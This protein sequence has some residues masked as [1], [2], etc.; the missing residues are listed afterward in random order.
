MLTTSLGQVVPYQQIE[1]Y[2]CGAA[3]LK[4]V[5][6]HWG[7]NYDEKMLIDL[8]GVD[9]M[10][11]S[12]ADQVATAAQRLGYNATVHQFD[13]I[14]ELRQYTDRDM[15]VIAA[16]RS[17]TRPGQG[18]FVV[19]AEVDD[20]TVDI[21]D[22][23]VDGN[24]RTLARSEMASRWRFRDNVGVIVTPRDRK[25]SRSSLG[26]TGTHSWIVAAIVGGLVAATAATVAVVRYR[27]RRQAAT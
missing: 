8:I 5:T 26:G 16:I 13:S 1:T 6:G 25:R 7:D 9:P 17:F 24:W 11:G 10:S 15:P 12:T 20:N 19:A 21:M 4:A 2:S 3:A 23:N 18:H 27:R 14:D 22:P